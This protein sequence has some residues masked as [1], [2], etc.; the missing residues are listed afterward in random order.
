MR[1]GLWY[2][3]RNPTPWKQPS[4]QLYADTLAQIEAAEPLGYDSVW[5]SEH[6]FVEDGYLPSSLLFL[7]AVAARTSR[8]RLGTLILLLPLH[9]PLRVAEDA[10][11][12]D[13]ISNGRVD[14]GVAAGYRV[15]EF[16][17]FQVPH[18]ERGARMDEGLAILQGAWA[19]GPFSHEGKAYSFRDVNVTPKPLQ[20]PVPIFMG[21]QSRAA[22]RRAAKYGCHLLPSSTTEFNLVEVYHEALREHGRDPA[23]FRIKCFR[24][25]YCCEDR[26]RGWDEVKAHYLYQHNLYR[27]WYREAGDSDAGELTNPDDLPRSSYIVGTPDDCERAIQDLH[28]DVPFDEFMFWASPPGFP[29][30]QS[31]RSVEL[32]AREVIPR[33][34]GGP[35]AG[36]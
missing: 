14:L 16:E 7:A 24:P 5:T 9:H 15:E 1:F 21:G 20:K 32:F 34:A 19:D 27:R 26:E 36:G 28:R 11:V 31:T 6:H 3:L 35:A 33:F 22:I 13:L 30:E 18:K 25:V 23:D 12:L 8:V 17:A 4:V 2:H 29:I 10:A